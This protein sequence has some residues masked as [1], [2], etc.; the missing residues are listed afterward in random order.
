ME[1]YPYYSVDSFA[2]GIAFGGHHLTKDVDPREFF[3]LHL[4]GD[5][6]AIKLRNRYL[7]HK[8]SPLKELELH[9]RK[10]S[11]RGILSHAHIYF[12][13]STDPFFP[14][15]GKFDASMRFLELFSKYSPGKLTIQTRSPLL[16]IALPVL[17]RFGE[18]VQIVYGI[19]SN[20]EEMIQEFSPGLPRVAERVKAIEAFKRFGIPIGIQVDPLLPYGDINKDAPQFAQFLSDLSSKIHV[21][22]LFSEGKN[23]LIMKKLAQRG[24]FQWIRNDSAEPLKNALSVICPEKLVPP[25]KPK[26]GPMQLKLFAA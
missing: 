24:L 18:N 14:F 6:R 3:G 11:K 13:V 21:R 4:E 22:P 23:E 1:M 16:V 19:E 17:K 25:P 5:G 7:L 20:N 26:L 10:L 12:G 2:N 8:E 15:E 9:L